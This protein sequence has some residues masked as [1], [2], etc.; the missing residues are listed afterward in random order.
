MTI[1]AEQSALMRDEVDRLVNMWI[2]RGLSM[3]SAS[4]TLIGYGLHM[5]KAGGWQTLD[6]LVASMRA[7]WPLMKEAPGKNP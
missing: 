6:Q 5:L 4:A 1:H 7:A 3:E 2:D